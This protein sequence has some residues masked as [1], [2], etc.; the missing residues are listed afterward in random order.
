MIIKILYDNLKDKTRVLTSKGVVSVEQD[1]KGV[2]VET[3]DG[4]VFTGDIL[5]G[6]DGVHSTVRREMWRIADAEKPGLF[7]L[8]E[9]NEVPTEYCCIFGISEPTNL[10]DEYSAQYILG[11]GHSYLLVSGVGGR[12]YWF[13]FKRLDKTV[14]GL[15][16]K[17]PR[18]TDAERDALAEEHA[19]DRFSEKLCF[20]D[21][22][23]LRTAATLQALPEVV[24]S[25]WHYGRMV[26]IGDA[27]HK[28]RAFL[29]HGKIL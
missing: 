9:R 4:D 8:K 22:Y 7:P 26:T 17:V 10:F 2:R 24:F 28:V 23:S 13:L 12:I 21:L 16:E 14:R 1:S 15:Y 29:R 18:Y 11:R 25:R 19:S 27:A 20:G 3:K 5:V 6:A